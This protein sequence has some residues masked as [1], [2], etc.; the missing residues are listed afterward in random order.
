MTFRYT[1]GYALLFGLTALLSHYNTWL[2]LPPAS[3]HQWRQADGAAIAWH[4]AQNPVIQEVRICNLFYTGDDHAAGE[5]PVLYWFSGLVSH[6]FGYPAYPLRWTGLLLLFAGGWAFGWMMLQLTRRPAIAA[7]GAGLLLTSPIL[8]YYGPCFLPDAPAFCFVLMMAACLLQADRRQSG[9]WLCAAAAGA[10][11]AILL[12]LSMAIAPLALG[13]TWVLGKRQRRWPPRTLWNSPWPIIA[14]AGTAVTVSAFRWWIAQYNAAHHAAYFLASIRPVWNYDMP[15]IRETIAMIGRSGLP[16]YAS[17]G[18]YLACAAALFITLKY[19]KSTLFAYRKSIVFTAFGSAAYVLLWFR[20]L[21]EHDYYVICLLIVPAM[22]L[23]NGL[24]LALSRYA[25]KNI[26]YALGFCWLL[27]AWHNHFILSKRLYLAF[28]PETSQNLPP[29][30][31][32]PAGQLAE[33]GIPLSARVLCPQDPS[34]NIALL[35]LQRSGWTAYNFGDR[36][37]VDTLY[38]YHTNFGLTH[39]ALRDTAFYS[40]VYRRFFPFRVYA[41]GGWYLYAH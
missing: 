33:A 16:A 9:A 17:A 28:H 15:F 27:G 19:W 26:L 36:I 34:P 24:R 12:K 22:L 13:I 40:P 29:D 41:A 35:A 3:I 14:L 37:T 10:A 25:E 18:L 21:R 11:L 6:Y 4:Y 2:T 1:C 23:L 39:L 30:A 20:M 7:P 31:F 32:L 5:F 38:K 8:T